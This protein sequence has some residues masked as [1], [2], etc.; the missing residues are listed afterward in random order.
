MVTAGREGIKQAT[1]RNQVRLSPRADKA[2]NV[3][4]PREGLC[5]RAR[6]QTGKID[7]EREE[8]GEACVGRIGPER[9]VADLHTGG[10]GCSVLGLMT[11][12]PLG[13]AH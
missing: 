7:T 1:V 6:C 3:R 2:T 12:F 11:C 5:G 13:E 9:L 8:E 10:T 4:D